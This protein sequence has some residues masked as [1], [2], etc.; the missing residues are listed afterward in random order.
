MIAW[1]I[2]KSTEDYQTAWGIKPWEAMTWKTQS[3]EFFE[4]KYIVDPWDGSRKLWLVGLASQYKPLHPVPE[5]SAPRKGTRKN[6]SNIMEYSCS[7]WAKA[8][9]RRT[10]DEDQ[11]VFEATY[12]SLKRN[13]LDEIE[14]LEEE[15]PRKCFIIL[16]PLKISPV[17]AVSSCFLLN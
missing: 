11:R 2:L 17:S 5:N 16:E 6:I 3:D 7:L 14:S 9:E 13:M 4:G 15:T 1:D 10:F 8:R 12:I